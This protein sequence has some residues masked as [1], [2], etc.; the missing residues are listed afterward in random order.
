MGRFTGGQ[1]VEKKRER[2][3]RQSDPRR[4]GGKK[5]NTKSSKPA[6][7][8]QKQPRN[9]RVR[10]FEGDIREKTKKAAGVAGDLQVF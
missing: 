5:K 10:N 6:P 3:G 8:R 4:K 2:G 9:V 7:L 1:T